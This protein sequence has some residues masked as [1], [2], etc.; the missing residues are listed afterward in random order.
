MESIRTKN[1]VNWMDLVRLA[2]EVDPVRA[3]SIIRQIVDNDR[4]IANILEQLAE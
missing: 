2:F 4:H 1:N 3:K